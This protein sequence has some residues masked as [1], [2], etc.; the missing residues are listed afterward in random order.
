MQKRRIPVSTIGMLLLL[1]LAAVLRWTQ[2]ARINQ[3]VMSVSV[4][5]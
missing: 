3:A 4:D 2:N 5:G 1:T